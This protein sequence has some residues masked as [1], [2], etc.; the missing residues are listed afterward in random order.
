MLNSFLNS[1]NDKYA[2]ERNK[3]LEQVEDEGQR[4]R[5]TVALKAT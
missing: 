5:P 2:A 3:V 1:V 4:Q